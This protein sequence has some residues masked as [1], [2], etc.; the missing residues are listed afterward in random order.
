MKYRAHVF[1]NYM[2]FVVH[3][4]KPTADG[5]GM[6]RGRVKKNNNNDRVFI[7]GELVL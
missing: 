3:R 2:F 6:T 5:V 7:F 1:L 4:K